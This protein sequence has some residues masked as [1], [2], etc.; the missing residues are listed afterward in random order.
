M[1]HVGEEVGAVFIGNFAK[2]F[3]VE[4]SGVTRDAGD[5]HVGMEETG[6]LFQAVVVDQT[7]RGIYLHRPNYT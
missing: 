6:I 1:C 4:I 7:G 5:E 2:S 3:V